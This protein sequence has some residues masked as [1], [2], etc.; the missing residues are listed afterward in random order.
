MAGGS[1]TSGHRRSMEEV[2]QSGSPTHTAATPSGIAV[3]ALEGLRHRQ[4]WLGCVALA[5]FPR[6]A[7]RA[8]LYGVTA[9]ARTERL[10]CE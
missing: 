4:T 7:C 5:A 1:S 8:I 9:K 10:A 2:T 6:E 3:P